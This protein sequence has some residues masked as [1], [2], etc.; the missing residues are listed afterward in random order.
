MAAR[1]W[2][3][4]RAGFGGCGALLGSGAE[5]SATSAATVPPSPSQAPACPSPATPA[6]PCSPTWPSAAPRAP[7]HSP[8]RSSTT[9]GPAPTPAS[10]PP[11]RW[12]PPAP[13]PA[14][15]TTMTPA[16][17][18]P[19]TLPCGC[20]NGGSPCETSSAPPTPSTCAPR[21]GPEHAPEPVL[22]AVAPG[23][24]PR[25]HQHR[26]RRPNRPGFCREARS[27]GRSG[28]AGRTP[29][30][31]EIKE[32]AVRMVGEVARELRQR[33]RGDLGG[34]GPAGSGVAGDGAQVAAPRPGRCRC[35]IRRDRNHDR[36][37]TRIGTGS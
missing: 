36:P 6:L 29:Y 26:T 12:R 10:W 20:G 30:P 32:R 33:V 27:R 3:A 23:P 15:A 9:P 24:R 5:P 18:P 19:S 31:Q 13:P 11:A 28:L 22:L 35:T 1:C 21:H 4:S 37:V 8:P 2:A 7:R 16:F 25:P 14:C 17:P 34:G